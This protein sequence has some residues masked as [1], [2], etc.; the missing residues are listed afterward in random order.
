M[1]LTFRLATIADIPFLIE[2]RLEFL[3]EVS[4]EKPAQATSLVRKSLEEYFK[5]NISSGNYICWIAEYD[6]NVV[7]TGGMVI[8]M[9]PANYGCPNGR[10]GYIMNM[11]TNPEFRKRGVCTALLDKLV[12]TAK[13]KELSI[14]ELHATY[15][16][17]PLYLKYG[18]AMPKSKVLEMKVN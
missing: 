9:Q 4:G 11:F 3:K 6:G 17:E 18:F 15:A 7:G 8:R 5:S 12:E 1:Q 10:A 16:G 13:E 14:L 2:N